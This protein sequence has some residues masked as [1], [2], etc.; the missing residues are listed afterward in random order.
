MIIQVKKYND[1]QYTKYKEAVNKWDYKKGGFPCLAMY[2]FIDD[3]GE[4]R[5]NG[6]VT[7]LGKEHRLHKNKKLAFEYQQRDIK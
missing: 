5:K 2:Q 7:I 4:A 1:R 6:W 3:I